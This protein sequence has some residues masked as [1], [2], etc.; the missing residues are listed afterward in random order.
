MPHSE[1]LVRSQNTTDARRLRIL[2]HDFAG[3]PFQV[4]LSRWLAKQGH[5]VTHAYCADIETPRGS[6]E[7][8]DAD[9]DTFSVS[10]VSIGRPISK[11]NLI[12]RI[13][14]ELAYARRLVD[15]L[16]TVRPD[17]VLSANASPIIQAWA[18]RHTHK[19]RGRFHYW[20]QDVYSVALDHAVRGLATVATLP[21]RRLFRVLE[22]TT[23]A[24]SDGV[25]VISEDFQTL[26]G[27]SGTRV[28]RLDVIENWAPS[29]E[30]R[31]LPK[32]NPWS[33]SLDLANK[34]VFL[35]SGTLGMKHNPELL[36]ALA[37]SFESDS[38]VRIVVISQGLG[39]DW[40]EQRKAQA[41]LDNL[42]LLDF[43]P[44][45]VLPSCLG[46]ADVQ[47]AILEPHAG[48]LSVPS[49]V[50]TYIA[51][52]KPILGAI[53]P[54]NL[55]SKIISQNDLGKTVPPTQTDAFVEA[56]QE[57]RKADLSAYTANLKDYKRNCFAIDRIGA[58]FSVALN[59]PEGSTASR[60][61][62]SLEQTNDK[63]LAATGPTAQ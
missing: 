6:L 9:P 13:L 51:A 33:Q 43:V 41:G 37:K 62:A 7:R 48:V 57:L 38:N 50:L 34:F 53:P 12:K 25:I 1:P 44:F 24:K 28:K 42:V 8:R 29:D 16:S 46:A 15:L 3:H 58:R 17:I 36:A 63:I 54:M 18:C 39:R 47:I 27:E 56:A 11:Y 19:N 20:L 22:F 26:I 14:D 52:E 31:L 10:A 60:T 2:V 40:L 4:Q 32:T 35:Y 61:G 30:M 45:E 23:L 59:L 49:K 21:L 5:K 55:A